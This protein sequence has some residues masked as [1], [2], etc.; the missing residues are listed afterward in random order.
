MFKV[1]L[2]SLA[3]VMLLVSGSFSEDYITKPRCRCVA[4]TSGISKNLIKSI[5]LRLPD[6][7]CERTEVIATL[8][9]RL[10]VC[11]DPEAPMT[12]KIIDVLTRPRTQ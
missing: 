5:E 10:P 4:T 12:K 8:K 6:G 1:K 11:L 2:L 3:V 9:T 7:V